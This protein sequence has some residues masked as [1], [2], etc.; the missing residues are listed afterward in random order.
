MISKGLKKDDLLE[1]K[2]INIK[3]HYKMCLKN[4]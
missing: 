4:K 1:E 3:L 2:F